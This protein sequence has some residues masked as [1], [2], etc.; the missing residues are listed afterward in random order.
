MKFSTRIDTDLSS[1][2]LFEVVGNFNGL[3]RMLIS[4]GATV[5][6]ITPSN[7]LGI[8][9]GW[10]VGFDLRG[11]PR[12]L[13]LAVTEFER[14][15]QI[16]ISGHSEALNLMVVATVITLSRVKS[17]VIFETKV[18]P[19]NMRAR[20]ILQTAKLGKRQLDHRYQR[21][22]EAFLQQMRNITR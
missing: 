11:K 13:Q 16:K 12:K 8:G 9:M 18:S 10:N 5:A 7:G 6:R 19:R 21:R 20:L 22:I 2:R 14:P 15:E 3:E 17:R 1:E 4:H